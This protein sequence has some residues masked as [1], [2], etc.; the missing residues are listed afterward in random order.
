MGKTSYLEDLAT[1]LKALIVKTLTQTGKINL[2]EDPTIQKKDIIEYDR[3]MRVSGLEKFNGPGFTGGISFYRS[4]KEKEERKGAGALA[5]FVEEEFSENLLKALGHSGLDDESDEGLAAKCAQ[6]CKQLAEQFRQEIATQGYRDLVLSEPL[7]G[8]NTIAQ[9]LDFSFDQYDKYE[10]N[11]TIKGKKVL[12]AELT[13]G[14][15]K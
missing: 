4:A 7:G 9:G 13:M 2:T 8:R 3:R 10:I 15:P 14:P 6:Y 5:I 12:V 1:K 11:L